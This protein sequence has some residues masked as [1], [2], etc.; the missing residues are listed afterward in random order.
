MN[1]QE[2]IAAFGGIEKAKREC[3]GIVGGNYACSY[4]MQRA[5]ASLALSAI[6]AP[7]DGWAALERVRF[8]AMAQKRGAP[9]NEWQR[10]NNSAIDWIVRGIDRELAARP[11]KE[12][13]LTVAE[14]EAHMAALCDKGDEDAEVD[15]W[16]LFACADVA[17]NT[18]GDCT[19]PHSYLITKR[20]IDTAVRI[21]RERGAALRRAEW[22]RNVAHGRA[23]KAE[24]EVARLR[25]VAET[26]LAAIVAKFKEA[27]K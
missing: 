27:T 11:A 22:E 10:G 24:A 17:T 16:K 9:G 4:Q 19:T 25:A 12:P 18:D 21:M 20:E 8:N 14:T 7:S 15:A 26:D 3:E 6:D 1:K 2:A 13:G 23:A 5:L